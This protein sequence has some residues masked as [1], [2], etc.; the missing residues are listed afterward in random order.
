MKVHASVCVWVLCSD[1][2]VLPCACWWALDDRLRF[3][4]VKEGQK[5]PIHI[6]KKDLKVKKAQH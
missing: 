1:A 2:D 5:M 4:A 6:L 3:S